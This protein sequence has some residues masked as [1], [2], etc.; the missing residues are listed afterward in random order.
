MQS[1]GTACLLLLPVCALGLA[2]ASNATAR[3]D[4]AAES[5]GWHLSLQCWTFNDATTFECIDRAREM[6]LRYIELYPGQKLRPGS[7]AQTHHDM[8]K[9]ERTELLGKLKQAGLKVVAYG[10]VD[11]TGTEAD[12]KFFEFAKAVGAETINAEPAPEQLDAIEKLAN[13]YQINVALH[14]HPKPSRYWDPQ[15]AYAAVKGHGRRIGL[16]ADVGHWMRS[17]IDPVEALKKYGDR[18]L[19][20]HFKDLNEFGDPA[21]HDVPWGTGAGKTQQVLMALKDLKFKGPLSIEY[22]IHPPDQR[23][24]VAQCVANFDKQAAECAKKK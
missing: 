2:A 15:V 7:D 5:L 23:A 8:S 11:L 16:C 3:D 17:G 1:P 21:A 20:F 9:E 18:V 24:Q 12:R 13:E 14:N 10:V 19:G 4:A 22:E 6:G